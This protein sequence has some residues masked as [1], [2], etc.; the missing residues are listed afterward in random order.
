L[1]L[2]VADNGTGIPDAKLSDRRSLGLL[3]MKERVAL[4]G[5]ELSIQAHPGKGTTITACLPRC[6]F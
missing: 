2:V 5:G 4:L 6:L 1:Q 3:G